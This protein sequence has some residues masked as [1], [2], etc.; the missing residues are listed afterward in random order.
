VIARYYQCKNKVE[1]PKQLSQIANRVPFPVADKGII[2]ERAKFPKFAVGDNA[3]DR[4]AAVAIQLLHG[5]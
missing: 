1:R 5:D 3:I 2:D 4:L